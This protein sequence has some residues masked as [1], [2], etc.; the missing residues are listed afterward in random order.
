MAGGVQAAGSGQLLI[1]ILQIEDDR[2]VAIK[3]LQQVDD[4]GVLRASAG[5]QADVEPLRGVRMRFGLLACGC[6]G[7]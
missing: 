3:D 2:H 6:L 5:G 4:L 7:S 1:G